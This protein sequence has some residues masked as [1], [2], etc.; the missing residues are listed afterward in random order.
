MGGAGRSPGSLSLGVWALTLELH[1]TEPR[2]EVLH[3]GPLTTW[4]EGDGAISLLV[5]I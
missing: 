2:S 1:E 3:Q 5:P 4:V